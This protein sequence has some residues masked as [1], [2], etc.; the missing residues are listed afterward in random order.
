[1]KKSPLIKIFQ[2]EPGKKI[3]LQDIDPNDLAGY[4]F[5]KDK[6]GA[7][8]E[9]IT[10]RLE[11]LQEMLYAEQKHKVLVILQAMDT[12]GKDGAI[13][14]VFEGVNPQGVRVASFKAPTPPE[15][16]HDF[17]WRIHQQA[18]AKGE[19]VIFNRSHY[20]DVLAVRV[21]DL[22][23]KKVWSRRFEHINQFEHMLADEGALI[24]KFFLHIDEEEQKKRLLSRLEDRSKQ[25]KF[26]PADVKEREFW[27]KYMAA[28]QDVFNRTSTPWAPWHII[29]SNRKWFRNLIIGKIIVGALENLNIRY[30]KSEFDLE[31]IKIE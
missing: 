17:L 31:D 6:A 12:A 2:L 29:P 22:A 4:A 3:K 13:R 27:P 28:Y 19:I 9:K 1:M 7:E 11:V 26:N 18:P 5:G 20:E 15:L 24:L 25:W 30:P 16:S 14:H 23:P 10:A 8:I 21:H